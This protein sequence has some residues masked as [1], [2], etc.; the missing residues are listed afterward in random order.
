MASRPI[1]E[2]KFAFQE[3]TRHWA[4]FQVPGANQCGMD[5]DGQLAN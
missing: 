2:V 4:I 1:Y 5:S 3:A